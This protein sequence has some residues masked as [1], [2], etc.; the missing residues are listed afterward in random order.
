MLFKATAI[1]LQCLITIAFRSN[2]E[3]TTIAITLRGQIRAIGVK[4][5]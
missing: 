1:N 3:Y 4:A 2:K 5:I